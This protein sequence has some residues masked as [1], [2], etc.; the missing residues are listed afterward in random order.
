M[1]SV[2]RT[3]P[4][5]EKHTFTVNPQEGPSC[6]P[7]CQCIDPKKPCC[8]SFMTCFLDEVLIYR[9]VRGRK[10]VLNLPSPLVT[11]KI[12]SIST[13]KCEGNTTNVSFRLFRLKFGEGQLRLRVSTGDTDTVT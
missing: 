4:R 1:S 8:S 10:P 9:W 5:P 13:T 3:R 12:S 6:F 7:F 11:Y 2:Q